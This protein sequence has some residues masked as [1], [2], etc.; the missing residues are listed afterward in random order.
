MSHSHSLQVDATLFGHL[1]QFMDAPLQN[2]S[3]KKFIE[4]N[5]QNLMEYYQRI[6]S[7]YW[8]DWDKIIQQLALNKED[9]K[10]EA[11]EATTAPL[12]T[13]TNSC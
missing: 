13:E 5:A 11:K 8:P 2:D 7:E 12:S 3:F 4:Q 1:A 6:K 9:I 10:E